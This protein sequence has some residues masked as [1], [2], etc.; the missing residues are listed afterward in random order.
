[1]NS[2]TCQETCSI[3]GDGVNTAGQVAEENAYVLVCATSCSVL[4]NDVQTLTIWL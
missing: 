3:S 1:M 2:R 4:R